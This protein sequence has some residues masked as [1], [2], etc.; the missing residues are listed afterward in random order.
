MTF[1]LF[2]GMITAVIQTRHGSVQPALSGDRMQQCIGCNYRTNVPARMQ[3]HRDASGHGRMDARSKDF[4]GH[5]ST[6]KQRK[7]KSETKAFL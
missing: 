4:R 6:R 5:I 3:K 7:K 2:S 1:L